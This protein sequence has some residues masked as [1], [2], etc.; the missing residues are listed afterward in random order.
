MNFNIVER[1]ISATRMT[2]RLATGASNTVKKRVVGNHYKL[3]GEQYDDIFIILDL[4]DKFDAILGLNWLMRYE[5]RVSWQH[6]LVT[7]AATCS[8]DKDLKMSWNAHIYV[9]ILRASAMALLVVRS[10]ARLYKD[11][12]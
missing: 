9:G 10:L 12:T 5:P 3:K 6:R 4:D 8:S 11:T 7:K 2:V 1:E